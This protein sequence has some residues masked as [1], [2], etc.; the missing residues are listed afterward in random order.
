MTMRDK[1]GRGQMPPPTEP[2]FKDEHITP[3]ITVAFSVRVFVIAV[4]L[5]IAMLVAIALFLLH[6]VDQARSER[7]AGRAERLK[8]EQRLRAEIANLQA[9]D[10]A[11]SGSAAADDGKNVSQAICTL[12]GHYPGDLPDI[13]DLR[14]EFS[15]FPY[16]PTPTPPPPAASVPPPTVT[17]TP[18]ATP[19][20]SGSAS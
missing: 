10:S 13:N 5:S 14:A 16:S 3:R 2:F 8:S 1:S 20:P 9:T 11:A 18:Q 19:S 4:M 6:A 17:S 15:C 12:I 7:H